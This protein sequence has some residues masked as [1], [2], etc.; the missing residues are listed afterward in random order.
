MT[1]IIDHVCS[2]A[3]TKSGVTVCPFPPAAY[4]LAF[5]CDAYEGAAVFVFACEVHLPFAAEWLVLEGA[6]NVQIGDVSGFPD[7]YDHAVIASDV[8]VLQP[9]GF[10]PRAL[11]SGQS[12]MT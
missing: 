7:A 10:P 3:I 4:L 9:V 12:M 2:G 5:D 6:E 11:L 1:E 8:Y